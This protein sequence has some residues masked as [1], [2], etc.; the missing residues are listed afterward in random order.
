ME[1]FFCRA[2]TTQTY[3]SDNCQ[4][5]HARLLAATITLAVSAT[6]PRDTPFYLRNQP[7]D[8][9]PPTIPEVYPDSL[10]IGPNKDRDYPF[11]WH[12]IESDTRAASHKLERSHA[13][14]MLQRRG[15]AS[16]RIVELLGALDGSSR[17]LI[18]EAGN[19]FHIRGDGSASP[20][21]GEGP[22]DP[23]F[24]PALDYESRTAPRKKVNKEWAA[25]VQAHNKRMG[26]NGP[27]RQIDPSFPTLADPKP[28]QKSRENKG[29]IIAPQK[30]PRKQASKSRER[31]PASPPNRETCKSTHSPKIAPNEQKEPRKQ[32]SKSRERLNMVD[33]WFHHGGRPIGA[34]TT[35]GRD[36]VRR[37]LR[38]RGF[39][40]REVAA[41]MRVQPA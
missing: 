4:H 5:E 14:V 24:D 29:E 10:F 40:R 18:R 12:Y 33:G 6:P 1:C 7:V 35:T 9:L 32:A 16:V 30:E 13:G 22:S 25:R 26:P 37:Y 36:L 27:L 2:T 3:C 23:Y 17:G 39:N 20:A 38:G 31:Q 28:Y 8:Y 11:A 34:D 41:M 15:I 21:A 19:M